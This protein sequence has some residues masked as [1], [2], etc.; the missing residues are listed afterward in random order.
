M[1]QSPNSLNIFNTHNFSILNM[2]TKN[3][4]DCFDHISTDDKKS[5]FIAGFMTDIVMTAVLARL[6]AVYLYLKQLNDQDKRTEYI[7]ETHSELK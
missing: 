3:T 6:L 2:K 1:D 5:M 7:Q 4:H